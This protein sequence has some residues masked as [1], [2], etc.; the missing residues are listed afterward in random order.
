MTVRDLA[1]NPIWKFG[2]RRPTILKSWIAMIKADLGFNHFSMRFLVISH[3]T[4]IIW[5]ILQCL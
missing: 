5:P 2:A 4:E 3:I 1:S